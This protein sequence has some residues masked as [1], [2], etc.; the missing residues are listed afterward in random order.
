MHEK[1]YAQMIE[2][3]KSGSES[4]GSGMSIFHHLFSLEAEEE[5]DEPKSPGQTATRISVVMTTMK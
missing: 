4:T 5:D 2:S 3:I 1:M